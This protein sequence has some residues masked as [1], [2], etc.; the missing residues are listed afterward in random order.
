LKA[1]VFWGLMVLL[2]LLPQAVKAQKV[3]AVV[4]RNIVLYMDPLDG[5]KESF[6][7]AVD[8][9]IFVNDPMEDRTSQGRALRSQGDLYFIVGSY[10]ATQMK[11]VIGVKPVLYCLI[12]RPEN[13][14]LTGA[15]V[16]GVSLRMPPV[17]E[18][19]SLVK[20]VAPEEQKVGLLYRA[21]AISNPIVA[22]ARREGAKLG[23]TVVAT[24]AEDEADIPNALVQLG[25][26]SRFIILSMDQM[27]FNESTFSYIART[28]LEAKVAVVV[29]GDK[30][31][32]KGAFCSVVPDFRDIGRLAGE[33]AN[34][35]IA[36]GGRDFQLVPPRKYNILINSRVARML[37][38]EIPPDIEGV[39]LLR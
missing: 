9:Y 31:V 3:T 26:E 33:M 17:A 28:S 23:I 38:I 39:R 7:G 22:E 37:G 13:F 4:S 15:K 35:I 12:S 29:S 18:M 36:S 1:R 11:D 8:S 21:S 2:L 25:N 20:K 16:A 19:L 27:F 14:N 6:K 32:K 24:G 30:Y 5:F 34:R 10:A